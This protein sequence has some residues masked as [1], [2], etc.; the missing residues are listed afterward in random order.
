MTPVNIRH[1]TAADLP[2]IMDVFNSARA[3]MRATGNHTQWDE[4]YPSEGLVR[5]DI[6][7]GEFYV[8]E[9]EDGV[10]HACFA[11]ILGIDPYYIELDGAWLNDEPYGTLH[12]VASDGTLR[13][14]TDIAVAYCEQISRNLRIDT[15]ADNL[16]MQ[17]AIDRAG[18]E[19]CGII[20][21]RDGTER[22]AYHRVK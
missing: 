18:F 8:V 10:V 15:H 3:F 13:G 17:K 20:I 11:F 2:Q 16:P 6:D 14:V 19:R 4:N 7:K 22:I 12:R 5:E 9:G 1:A 21:T